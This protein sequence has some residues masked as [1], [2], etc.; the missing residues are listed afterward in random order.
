M[1]AMGLAG[2]GWRGPRPRRGVV[3]RSGGRGEGGGG[4]NR[5]AGALTTAATLPEATRCIWALRE[6]RVCAG[7]SSPPRAGTG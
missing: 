1:D 7:P 2:R 3:C 6:A 5:A 4:W